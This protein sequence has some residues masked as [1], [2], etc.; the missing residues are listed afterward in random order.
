MAGTVCRGARARATVGQL[1]PSALQAGSGHEGIHE[2]S[3]QPYVHTCVEVHIIIDT[4]G[5]STQS[6]NDHL[7]ATGRRAG[8]R[9]A[10][11]A[12]VCA[13][14]YIF[15]HLVGENIHRY[16]MSLTSL[17]CQASELVD[18]DACPRPMAPLSPSPLNI[19]SAAV[20]VDT[21]CP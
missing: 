21:L 13:P 19:W 1:R 4:I 7:Y 16:P 2:Y 9:A 20:F 10:R 11:R 5:L 12:G 15:E 18:S 17:Q 3:R 8:Q 6:K 14:L